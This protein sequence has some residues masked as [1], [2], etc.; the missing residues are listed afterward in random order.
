MSDYII[1]NGT[2]MS[3]ELYHWGVKGMRWGVR[4]YQNKDG[5]LTPLGKQHLAEKHI[6]TEENLVE[7]TIPKGTK[8]YRTTP[9][10]KDTNTSKS[11]YVT[12]LE[13]DRNLY[14]EGSVVKSYV[15]KNKNDA[16]VYEHEY[17][18]KSDIHI[19]SLKTVREIEKK[20]VLDSV[21]ARQ[22]VGKAWTEA[23]LISSYGLGASTVSELSSVADQ[24]RRAKTKDQR[25]KI[26]DDMCRKYGDFLGDEYYNAAQR[27]NDGRSMLDNGNNALAIEQSLGRAKGVKESIIN[28]LKKQGYN[29]MYDNAGIGVSSDGGYTK[30]QEGIEPLIIFDSKATLQEIDTRRVDSREQRKASEDYMKWKQDVSE[31]L[32]KFK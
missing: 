23:I 3:E 13:V 17:S 30:W 31:T 22:E 11:A 1:Y 7:K 5:T 8:M 19:P 29:A 9:F 2:L 10:E 21:K 24:I 15:N 28:E 16:S 14:K 32:K 6:R 25:I 26:Y 12:Y 18:L 27:I 20:V 4:R